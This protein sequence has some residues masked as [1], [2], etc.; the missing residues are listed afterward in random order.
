MD[1]DHMGVY[2]SNQCT[3][4]SYIIIDMNRVLNSRGWDLLRTLKHLQSKVKDFKDVAMTSSIIDGIQN[5]H[6]FLIM[7]QQSRYRQEN[8][9][10]MDALC[11]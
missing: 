8:I 11:L 6:F 5:I 9:L 2:M 3:Y 7:M 10:Q 4:N 1:T